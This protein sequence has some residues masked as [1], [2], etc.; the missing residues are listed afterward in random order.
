MTPANPPA[1][2]P[3][4]VSRR[5]HVPATAPRLARDV[6]PT[7]RQHP[8]ANPHTPMGANGRA[9][10]PW[11]GPVAPRTPEGIGGKN[12]TLLNR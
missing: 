11:G 12:P 8:R 4:P 2:Y 6:P 3:R 1:M 9:L 5:R 7:A 10:G